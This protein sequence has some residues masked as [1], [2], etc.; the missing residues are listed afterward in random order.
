MV[1]GRSIVVLN[2]LQ[3]D[4]RRRPQV[5][6]NV[7]GDA[8]QVGRVGREVLGVV[9]A[10]RQAGAVL[11]RDQLGRRRQSGFLRRDDLDRRQREDA[12]EAEGVGDDSGDL[13]EL[14]AEFGIQGIAGA[15]ERAA[16]EDG[17]GIG[18][19]PDQSPVGGWVMDREPH[20]HR[21][22][23]SRLCCC[24]PSSSSHPPPTYHQTCSVS[25]R[26]WASRR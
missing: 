2:L 17:L 12:V 20:L 5:L 14:V 26:P 7:S 3:E 6:D 25:R 18:I 16:D 19:Y 23:S 1:I 24:V 13:F 4:D 21:S 10:E 11:G 22:W 8:R 9:D 15:V